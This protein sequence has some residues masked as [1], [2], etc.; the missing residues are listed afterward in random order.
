[1]STESPGPIQEAR[2]RGYYAL[3][4]LYTYIGIKVE[5]GMI[6]LVSTFTQSSVTSKATFPIYAYAHSFR[7][8]SRITVRVHRSL[9]FAHVSTLAEFIIV[10][11]P[12]A[13]NTLVCQPF[14]KSQIQICTRYFC[15]AE[16]IYSLPIVLGLLNRSSSYLQHLRAKG[17]KAPRGARSLASSIA[18][19]FPTAW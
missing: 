10:R 2:S 12:D 9:R 14:R 7:T 3:V 1:M 17:C 11:R 16:R 18:N 5:I 19:E 6:F 15:I 13:K 8:Y 4:L